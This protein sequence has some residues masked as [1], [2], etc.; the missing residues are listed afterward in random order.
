MSQHPYQCD[1]CLSRKGE[2]GQWWLR[3]PEAEQFTLLPWDESRAGQSGIEHICS[4]SCASKALWQWMARTNAQ[5]ARAAT[6]SL[7]VV[8]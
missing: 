6:R 1:Y 3:R 4:A 7:L 5:S 8:V 2:S